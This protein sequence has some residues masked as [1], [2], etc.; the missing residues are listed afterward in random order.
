MSQDTAM[1]RDERLSSLLREA[2]PAPAARDAMFRIQV[3]ELRE[4]NR[5]RRRVVL[6]AATGILAGGIALAG[7]VA[8][9]ELRV[10]ASV[11]LPALAAA[12]AGINV[13]PAL[14]RRV[15]TL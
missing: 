4:R 13:A 11:A 12:I 5:F 3:L 2:A 7:L 8:G 6:T 10:A 9:G 15:W 1:E 14:T